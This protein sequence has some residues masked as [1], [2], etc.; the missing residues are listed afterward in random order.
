[1]TATATEDRTTAYLDER[2][3]DRAAVTDMIVIAEEKRCPACRALIP[4]EGMESRAKSDVHT[5]GMFIRTVAVHCDACG[6]A[7]EA[8]FVT[9]DGRPVPVSHNRRLRGEAFQQLL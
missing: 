3:A 4:P 9:R 1:M 6:A 8:D 2:D 5:Y 7:H